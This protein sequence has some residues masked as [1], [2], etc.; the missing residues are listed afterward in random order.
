VR[1]LHIVHQYV[2]E[3]VAGTELYT[4]ALADNQVA[5]GHETAVFYPSESTEPP[6]TDAAGVRRYGVPLGP[7]S[8]TQVF[9]DTFFNQK[10]TEAF[11]AVLANEKPDII[12]IQHLMGLP[13]GLV[14]QIIAAGIPY[15][16]TLHDYWYGCANGQL[17]TNTENTIC[18][19]PGKFYLNC[20]R[21]A[22][23]RAGQA[24]KS[25]LAP[26]I[27]PLLAYRNGRLRR[28]LHHAKVVIPPTKFV[29]DTYEA[30]GFDTA[31]FRH[32]AHGI[33]I[34]QH[35]IQT[36]LAQKEAAPAR[37]GLHIGYVGSVGWQK[38]VHVLV[39]A[40]NQ[41]PPEDVTLTL[42]GGLG[43][44]PDYV[45][46]LRQSARHPGITFAGRVSR[47]DV[48]AAIAACDVMVMPTLWYEASPLTIDE[49]FAVRVPLVGS[50]IGALVE[51]IEDGVNG[52][53][54]PPGDADSLAQI[55][56]EL[57]HD[58]S[59]IDRLRAA[60]KPVRTIQDHFQELQSIYTQIIQ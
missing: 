39:E 28:I 26:G 8:R 59:Q 21:C 55:L 3:H 57:Y 60:I 49:M 1:I 58:K 25:W 10:V 12:H 41:L 7:R 34:P 56:L 2:P 51:K 44:F 9:R 16:V 32:V 48:W 22:L 29:Q 33:E 17:I 23:A 35:K 18:A 30:M 5:A 42:Y 45:A 36:V 40:V 54:F 13:V 19:G 43:T 15:V 52:R 38:G 46:G 50:R 27:A 24:G 37:P 4:Q 14:D 11:T 20:G 47:D 6:E 31:N 53:L